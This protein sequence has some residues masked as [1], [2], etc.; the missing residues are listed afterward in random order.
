VQDDFESRD[1]YAL[2]ERVSWVGPGAA[3]TWLNIAQEYTERWHHQQHMREALARPGFMEE[4]FLRPALDTFMRGLPH[5]YRDVRAPEDTVIQVTIS[6]DSGGAWLLVREQ[7][8][9]S[10]YIG[11]ATRPSAAAVIPQEI[12]W[13]LFTKWATKEEA[14][15]TSEIQGERSL[16]LRVFDMV[17]VIA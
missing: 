1:P 12:A 2:G 7:N 17:S 13:R 8:K 6:G 4:R 10:H 16:V 11:S 3:P 5:T 14:L 15:R 9:W